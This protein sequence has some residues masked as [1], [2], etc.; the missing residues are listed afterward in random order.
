MRVNIIK[1]SNV[2]HRLSSNSLDKNRIRETMN[3]LGIFTIIVS[4]T[5]KME[6]NNIV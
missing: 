2:K 1:L 3:L 5:E 6:G 4:T